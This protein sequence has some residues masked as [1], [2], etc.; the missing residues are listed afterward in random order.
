MRQ[1]QP[2]KLSARHADEGEAGDYSD[3]CSAASRRV[4]GAVQ[5]RRTVLL[6][7][8]Q[9]RLC[10]DQSRHWLAILWITGL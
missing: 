8:G 9:R 7:A 6:C 2:E 4:R 3:S 5:N 1:P 10:I